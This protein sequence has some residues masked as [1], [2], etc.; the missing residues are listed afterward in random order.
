[1]AKKPERP[2]Q[3]RTARIWAW[4]LVGFAAAAFVVLAWW[5][6]SLEQEIP[7]GLPEQTQLGDALYRTNCAI[8]HGEAGVGE[9]PEKP[10]GGR[11]PDGG[12]IAPAHNGNGHTWHHPPDVLFKIVKNG[13][14]ASDSPMKGW[15]DRLKDEEIRAILAYILSL[16][17][18]DLRERYRRTHGAG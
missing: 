4:G 6:P 14:P 5:V 2:S 7:A 12:Y 11:K 10:N 16:W 15:K 17:P 3:R 9:N 8:C 18:P 13:S 1:M